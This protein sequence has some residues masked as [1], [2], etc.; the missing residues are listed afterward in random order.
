[1]EENSET[2]SIPDGA[3][4]E[5]ANRILELLDYPSELENEEDLF[6]DDF[7]I[8]IVGNLISDAK[9]DLK[10]GKDNEEK[11]ESLKKLIKLLQEII[12]MDLSHINPE[13]IIYKHDKISTK[14]LLELIEELIKALINENEKEENEESDS[15]RKNKKI[16]EI[17]QEDFSNSNIDSINQKNNISEDNNKFN[18][19]MDYEDFKYKKNSI[20]D[21]SIEDLS[22]KMQKMKEKNMKEEKEK[23]LKEEKEKKLKEEKEKKEKMELEKKL[24]EEKEKKE[25]M[26]LEKKLKEEKEKME[27]E[28][29]LKEEKEKKNNLST[30]SNKKNKEKKNSFENSSQQSSLIFGNRSCFEPLDFEKA[31]KNNMEHENGEDSYIRKTF[32]QNDISRYEREL[33]ENEAVNQLN[34]DNLNY[35]MNDK[36]LTDSHIMNVSNISGMTHSNKDNSLSKKK[37][38]SEGEI[39]DL[40]NYDEKKKNSNEKKEKK[41]NINYNNY[42][43]EDDSND[44]SNN[45]IEEQ[46]AHSVPNAPIRMKLTTTSD[47][48][49]EAS[50]DDLDNDNL[51]KSNIL[52]ESSEKNISMSNSNLSKSSKKSF[53]KNLK[54]NNSINNKNDIIKKSSSNRKLSAKKLNTNSS[55]NNISQ[56][57]ISKSSI[58][59]QKSNKSKNKKSENNISKSS[60]S[61]LEE[62]PLDDEE[63]KYEIIKQFRR[64]YGDKIDRIF[65]KNNLQ[66][67]QNLFEIILRNIKLARTKM[68]KLENR[69]PENDDLLTKEFIHK[70]EKELQYILNYYKNEK[71]KRYFLQ[72]R[73]LKTMSQNVRVMKKIQEIQTKKMENEIEKKRKLREVKNHQNQLRLCNEIYSRALQLEKERYLEEISSQM[74]I[75]RI[76]NDEKRKAMME[77]EKYYTDKIAIL[78]EILKREKKDRAIEHNAQN[79]F[80]FQIQREKKGEFKR[81]IDE[82]FQRFDEED[83]KA[84]FE[85]NNQEQIEK[86]LNNYYKK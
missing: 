77:I 65:L 15:I 66:N 56:S 50:I 84:E 44:M 30:S 31:I 62:L 1:M 74:E 47:E 23:K 9:F 72:E 12:E 54:D 53:N 24:K 49:V 52:Q 5:I 75:R 86:I 46:S 45:I 20:D 63:F 7:Y 82:V 11:V 25:K 78:K 43:Y 60:S 39:P 16:E 57:D 14:C 69:I 70:Y 33:A 35:E 21:D 58:Q 19:H 40:L 26:E 29:Q 73:A 17:E 71:K 13:N 76:E 22:A 2:M 10:P 34:E 28:N 68:L 8:A 59:T 18:I 67:N 61:I 4:L 48:L 42:Y 32:T 27:M 37:K 36:N 41:N 64:L 79:Q 51:K 83:R 85:D 80:L 3:L 38:N 55:K 6:L 81:Q